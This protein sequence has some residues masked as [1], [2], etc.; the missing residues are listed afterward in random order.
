MQA[1]FA[2]F[3]CPGRVVHHPHAVADACGPQPCGFQH[4]VARI[5]LARVHGDAQPT[6]AGQV[7]RGGVLAGRKT[8]LW[9]GQV[10]AHHAIGLVTHGQLG[11]C[12][13]GVSPQVAHATH[14]EPTRH[15]AVCQAAQH[16]LQGGFWAQAP[17]AKQLWGKAELGQ[18]T[19]V[20]VGVFGQFPGHAFAGGGCGHGR[21]GV[22]K[23]LQ[24]GGQLARAG[25][26]QH[27]TGHTIGTGAGQGNAPGVAQRP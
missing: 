1:A 10:K 11:R 7:Q 9:P 23:A 2:G 19:A 3:L 12:P 6:V 15:G 21:H 27:P 14:D 4:A 5:G 8:Q 16:G 13:C 22:A 26:G 24:V 17:F 20:G 18:H 25:V